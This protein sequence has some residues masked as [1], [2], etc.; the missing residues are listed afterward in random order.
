[1]CCMNIRTE[2]AHVLDQRVN[3]YYEADDP[4]M[5]MV[6]GLRPDIQIISWE[7]R[8]WQKMGTL[9]HRG[10]RF[11]GRLA[12]E[13][14][15]FTYQKDG[16]MRPFAITPEENGRYGFEMNETAMRWA[17]SNVGMEEDLW[18]LRHT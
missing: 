10:P 13:H 4:L 2:A 17:F 11:A 8:D 6:D 16:E 14:F 1:M 7:Q 12:I 9:L 15:F 18:N 3:E 5:L